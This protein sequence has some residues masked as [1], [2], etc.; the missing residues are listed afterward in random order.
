MDVTITISVPPLKA[1]ETFKVRYRDYPSGIFGSQT[2]QT[3]APFII[4]G[5]SAGEYELE[6]ILDK[7][8]VDCPATLKRF[9]VI[10]PFE[11]VEFESELIYQTNGLASLVFTYL[12]ILVNPP[13]GWNILIVGATTN[14]NI[15]YATLPTSPLTIPNTNEPLF[16]KVLANMCN[17]KFMT[18]FEAD[19]P[20]AATPCTPLVLNDSSITLISQNLTNT[21]FLVTFFITQS[22]PPTTAM[23]V[24]VTQK[25]VLAGIPGQTSFGPFNPLTVGA[26]ATSF[27]VTIGANPNVFNKTYDFDFFI[28]DTC[29]NKTTGSAS[30]HI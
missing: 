6:V 11:C 21:Q 29:K 1:G 26:G 17:G 24:S 4:T 30:I 13:C 23:I 25:N 8:D 28:I 10:Q 18:C 16:V 20:K 7:G 9:K 3:N 15:P 2:V 19:I 27:S 5:L 12:P 14:K 22:V